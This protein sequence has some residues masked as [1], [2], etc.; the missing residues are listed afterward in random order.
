MREVS[1][2]AALEHQVLAAFT[3]DAPCNRKV[4][5]PPTPEARTEAAKLLG[6]LHDDD[7]VVD[8]SEYQRLVESMADH[9]HGQPA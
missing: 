6:I 3:T 7:T 5:R 4:N 2:H 1:H 9:A 8:L